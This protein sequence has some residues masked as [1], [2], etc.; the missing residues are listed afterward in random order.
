MSIGTI[1]LFSNFVN[2]HKFKKQMQTGGGNLRKN[3]KS[4]SEQTKSEKN[5]I[6]NIKEAVALLNNV[7]R[8]N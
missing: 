6:L 2:K 8:E 5:K 7:Y 4:K 1:D 3:D